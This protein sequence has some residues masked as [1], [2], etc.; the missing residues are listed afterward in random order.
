M[1][2]T[3]DVSNADSILSSLIASV[4]TGEEVIITRAGTAVAKIVPY[5]ESTKRFRFGSLKDTVPHVSLDSWE[6][7]DRDMQDV[8]KLSGK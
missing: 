3:V 4:E 6:R 2:Q 8:W 5:T 1:T 7:S